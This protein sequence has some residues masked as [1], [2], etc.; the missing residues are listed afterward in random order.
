MSSSNY[1]K[2]LIE[3]DLPIKRISE[4]ARR[5]KSIRHGHISTLHMWWA[6]RPLAACRAVI[7]ASL[8]PDPADERCPQGFRDE[9]S[10]LVTEFARKAALDKEL[11]S[12][13]SHDSWI[14]W[15]R[16]ANSPGLDSTN[17]SHL[18]V[19][20]FALLD[21]I[22][23]FAN[24]DN[25]T[26]PEY[27]ETS[28][29]LTHAAHVALGGGPETRPLVVDSFAGGGSIPLEALRVG[30]DSFAS[31][32]NPVAVLLNKVVL[33]YVPKCGPGLADEVRRWGAWVRCEAE[34]KLSEFYPPGSGG[35]TPIAYLWARTIICEGPGCGAELPLLKSLWIANKANRSVGY[36]L[37]P[38]RDTLKVE[39][40]LIVKRS[41]G[42][43]DQEDP[44]TKINNPTFDGTVKRGSATCIFCGYTTPAEHVREQLSKRGGGSKDARMTAVVQEHPIEGTQY[45]IASNS[46]LKIAR[47]ASERLASLE[48]DVKLNEFGFSPSESTPANDSHRSVSSLWIYG[49]RQW[50]DIYT[51]RQIV[52]LG[53]L[54]ETIAA[55]AKG[56][57]SP[58]AQTILA[59]CVGKVAG[60]LS[61][62]CLWRTARS[63]VANTFARQALP[64]VW[65]FGEMNPFAGS[66]GDWTETVEYVSM[67]IEATARSVDQAENSTTAQADATSHLL[68]SDSAELFATDP[69]YYD[70][71]AYGELSDYFY[72][73]LKRALPRELV[74]GFSSPLTPKDQQAVVYHP[75]SAI[76]RRR[77]ESLMREA[78]AEGRRIVKPTGTGVIVFAHKSTLGWETMLQALTDAGW[79]VTASW[80]V[81]TER[82]GRPNAN[83]TAS[84]ASSVHLTCRPR[85][86]DGGAVRSDEIGDWRD[87]LQALPVRIHEWMPRLAVEG[88]VGA[89]AIFSCLGPALEIFSRYP[90]VEK[91]SGEVVTLKEYLE[92][93]WAAVAKEALNMIFEGADATGFEEDSRLTAMWLWTL[94]T[95]PN[96]DED[97]PD[98]DDEEE[99]ESS[100]KGKMTGFVLEYDAARKI[101]QGLG[102]HLE[103]LN[104]L[105]AIEGDKACLLPVSERAR[106]LF[107][108]DAGEAPSRR[109]GK[110]KQL[111]LLDV[112]G[113]ADEED[114]AWG[115]KNDTKLGNTVLDRIHQSMILF[116]AGRGE[117]LKRFLVNDG[118]GQDQRFWRLAQAL[119][120]L[121]PKGTDERRWVEGVLARKKGLGF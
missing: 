14:K 25:S 52:V 51:A 53:I 103:Q 121:Y 4:H 64:V 109:K 46:D 29:A 107:G 104:S 7:C 87:I 113:D 76:E 35:A 32:L 85:Q 49:M 115:A 99:E 116:A 24:W 118:V 78:L 11:A 95:G 70:A 8:W 22:A 94:S 66:A 36:M 34:K 96:G 106:H 15:Q 43:V 16:L 102:A 19:L 31:D 57:M 111:S 12:H 67:F 38:N 73:W 65:D 26:V 39:F 55:A 10:R 69:P 9:A 71:V 21:F 81:D 92:Y 63:C 30:A 88:V 105:V 56:G 28:R 41:G 90:R 18:N 79:I 75:N 60:F 77:Y 68:P 119:S 23:D 2:R 27:L 47:L 110:P 89:D 74:A 72:V 62:L 48:R 101:A 44:A 17:E 93:V 61:T 33:E 120:A 58:I 112:L 54:C 108:K 40:K 13:C 59:L 80:P 84:L 100:K 3:V 50:R 97:R 37:V 5:E 42:W 20:R 1:P 117:A 91:A 98:E 82:E 6:R 45:R 83:R 114:G 86:H